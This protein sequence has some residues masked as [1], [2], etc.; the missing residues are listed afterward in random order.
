MEELEQGGCCS[1]AGGGQVGEAAAPWPSA[2][3]RTARGA[4]ILGTMCACVCV[5]REVGNEGEM[6]IDL[7]FATVGG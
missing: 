7:G 5:R 3:Q 1:A 2:E 4:L 6:G